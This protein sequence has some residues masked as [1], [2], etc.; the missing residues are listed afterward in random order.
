[1][2]KE[3]L[4]TRQKECLD[5][6]KKFRTRTGFIPTY[7]EIAEGLKTQESTAYMICKRTAAKGWLKL[8]RSPR[9][10]IIL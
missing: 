3:A 6:I 7:K 2:K 8:S 5:F 9:A 4:T 1:M 10:I